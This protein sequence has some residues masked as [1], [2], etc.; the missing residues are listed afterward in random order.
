MFEHF[1][2][3]LDYPKLIEQQS[4]NVKYRLQTGIPTNNKGK[5]AK[6]NGLQQTQMKKNIPNHHAVKQLKIGRK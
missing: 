1:W 3:W 2:P 6:K 5:S 4:K